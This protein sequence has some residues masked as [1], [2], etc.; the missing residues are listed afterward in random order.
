[1]NEK[2]DNSKEMKILI[3]D[4]TP[5]NIDVLWKALEPKGYK[6]SIAPNGEIALQILAKP[7]LPDLILL[8]IMMPG[9]DGYETCRRIKE[10]EWTC[11]IPVIFLTAKNQKEDIVK[12][13]DV[14]G[15]DYV[16]KPFYHDEIFARIETHLHLEHLKKQLKEKNLE[17]EKKNQDLDLAFSQA[18]EYASLVQSGFLPE[19]SPHNKNFIFAGKTFPAKTVGGDFYDFIPLSHSEMGLTLGDVS[20]KG[21]PAALYMARSVSDFRTLSH[22]NS[23]PSSILKAAN[24]IL[25]KRTQNGKFVTAIYL[26]LDTESRKLKVANAGH[27][28]I[29]VRNNEN[30][31][32]E[33]GKAGGPP[34]GILPNQDYPQE[35]IQLEKGNMVL[36]YTDGA[37]EPQN[38]EGT[39]FG[40]DRLSKILQ[41]ANGSPQDLILN[42]KDSIAHF[43][44]NAPPFDDL[45]FLAFKVL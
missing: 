11:N 10:N 3:V 29:M 39:Q 31:V 30:Q 7:P 32:V 17:L 23:E 36:L 44:E 35:E 21:V 9:I 4:D 25:Y 15:V 6:V 43:T 18:V 27:H 40:Q 42:L 22:L 38:K 24:S 41:Q 37:T 12:G 34:L 20:G 16:T 45:T 8:D 33:I 1:M 14:G 19:E 5:A 13:F 28:P 26:K 2:L